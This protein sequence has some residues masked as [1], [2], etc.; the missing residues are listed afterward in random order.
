MITIDQNKASAADFA[1]RLRSQKIKITLSAFFLSAIF[2]GVYLVTGGNVVAPVGTIV[3]V[4]LFGLIITCPRSMYFVMLIGACGIET[5][6]LGFADSTTD[7]V[8]LFWDVNTIFQTYL[9][10]SNFHAVPLSLFEV[11]LIFAG[12]SWLTRAIFLDRLKFKVGPLFVSILLYVICV[13]SGLLNGLATGGQ[14]NIALF[15]IRAQFYFLFAYLI[16]VNTCQSPEKAVGTILWASA[17]TIGLKGLLASF[18]FIVTLKGTTVP[19]T[20]I[21]AHEES[22]FFDCFEFQLMV[23]CLAGIQ[24]KL[25]RTMFFL[26][27][28]VLIANLANERRAA[29]A[30]LAI[31]LVVMLALGAIAFPH[32]R[33][34]ITV[35]AIVIAAVAAIYLPIFWNGT[36]TFAQPARAIKSQFTPDPRDASSNAYRDE[37]N[38]NLMYTMRVNPIF[39]YGYGKRIRVINDMVDLDSVDPFVHYMTHN[40][41]LWVWMR[42]G[43]VGFYIFWIMIT[44][45]VIKSCQLLKN[46]TA[47][48]QTRAAALLVVI[49]FVMQMIFGL[50]DL[51]I[52]NVRNMLYCGVWAGIIAYLSVLFP[53]PL[54]EHEESA[55]HV[56]YARWN[57]PPVEQQLH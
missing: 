30:A 55:V 23:L 51:Q 22:F 11:M 31:G 27:P 25:R 29:T 36:G 40:Q 14:F 24:L 44:S 47:D 3:A 28:G 18:R 12:L 10:I 19:E 42:L 16:A 21:G 37:E 26:L 9:H 56:S 57:I 45:I 4:V 1:D 6:Q 33:R 49:I 2:A 54:E 50:L 41:I 5:Y 15:E 35:T 13:A 32:R 20:G 43:T 8:P 17:L 53:V 39:G 38:Q 46:M 48:T 7:R 52:S 34:I